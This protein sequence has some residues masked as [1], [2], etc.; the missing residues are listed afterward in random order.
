MC[1][2]KYITTLS[3]KSARELSVEWKLACHMVPSRS[4]RNENK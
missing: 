3:N 1:D 4:L 2:I